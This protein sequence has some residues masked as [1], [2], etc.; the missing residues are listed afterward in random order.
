MYD[1]QDM[2]LQGSF[3]EIKK[4]YGDR[5]LGKAEEYVKIKL[6]MLEQKLEANASLEGVKYATPFMIFAVKSYHDKVSV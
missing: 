2:A 4:E 3:A 5:R 1:L 6:K